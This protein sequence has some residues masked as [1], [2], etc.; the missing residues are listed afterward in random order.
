MQ[1]AIHCLSAS[2]VTKLE[3]QLVAVG[4]RGYAARKILPMAA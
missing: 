4:G 1:V 2:K 3:N